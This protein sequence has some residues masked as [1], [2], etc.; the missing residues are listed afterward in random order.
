MTISYLPRY[1]D[2]ICYRRGL[3]LVEFRETPLPLLLLLLLLVLLLS[4][5][6]LSDS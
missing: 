2:G 6:S 4:L 5:F 1:E 3:V